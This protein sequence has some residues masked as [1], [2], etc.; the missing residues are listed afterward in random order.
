MFAQRR[1]DRVPW[2]NRAQPGG[3][4]VQRKTQRRWLRYLWMV[5]VMLAPIVGVQQANANNYDDGSGVNTI[6]VPFAA[7]SGDVCGSVTGELVWVGYDMVT[8]KGTLTDQ[9][10]PGQQDPGCGER[11]TTVAF[12]VQMGD[13]RVTFSSQVDNGKQDFRFPV[14]ESMVINQVTVRVCRRLTAGSGS[15]CGPVRTYGHP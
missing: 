11:L 9:P 8:I 1:P 10:I 2:S 12:A 4:S 13:Y 7:D 6:V 3:L 15:Y 5:P 14:N